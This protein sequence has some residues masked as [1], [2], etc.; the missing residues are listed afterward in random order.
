M[1]RGVK[2]Y[3]I[4][5][6]MDSLTHHMKHSLDIY[7]K[8]YRCHKDVERLVQVRTQLYRQLDE[9]SA[10]EYRF[11]STV[12][13]NIKIVNSQLISEYERQPSTPEADIISDCTDDD[14]TDRLRSVLVGKSV[15]FNRETMST[16]GGGNWNQYGF[17]RGTIIDVQPPYEI[18]YPGEEDRYYVIVKYDGHDGLYKDGIAHTLSNGDIEDCVPDSFINGADIL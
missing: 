8:I 4:S 7:R 10:L 16:D 17:D 13:A 11:A 12:T 18:S 6:D 2:G 3:F 9:V 14:D 5:V 15:K 1:R